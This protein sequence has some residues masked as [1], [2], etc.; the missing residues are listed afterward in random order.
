[1]ASLGE[2]SVRKQMHALLLL[3]NKK[4]FMLIL[5][6][7]HMIAK[8]TNRACYIHPEDQSK[9]IKVT[10]SN[11]HSESEKEAQYYR[12]LQ[13][14]KISWDQIARFYGNIETDL[15]L[16]YVFD[17]PR[18]YNGEVSK[19]LHFYLNNP[20]SFYIDNLFDLLNSLFDYLLEHRIIVKDLNFLNIL[21]QREDNHHGRVIIIDGL[22]N[23]QRVLLLSRLPWY[24]KRKILYRW[25]EFK[26]S[27]P[28]KCK[29]RN[30]YILQLKARSDYE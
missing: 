14:K 2:I 24:A 27:W 1:M 18:D 17:L 29:N 7:E 3:S 19:T 21:Y 6:H 23:S 10:I 15:G 16:G 20:E 11:D 13:A 5:A 12:F 30:D 25:D 22:G 26:A 8:G 9:C 4:L 28:K